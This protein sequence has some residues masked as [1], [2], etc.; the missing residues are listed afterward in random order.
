MFAFRFKFGAA[1]LIT[2]TAFAITVLMLAFASGT[3]S[4]AQTTST[5]ENITLDRVSFVASQ[6]W[7]L[8]RGRAAL[9]QDILI[10]RKY[11]FP[12]IDENQYT[13]LSDVKNIISFGCQR[14]NRHLDYISFHIPPWIQL[15]GIDRGN[16]ISQLD[17]RIL[18]DGFSFTPVAE[19][20]N[21]TLFV[22]LNDVFKDQLLRLIV[23]DKI[24]VEFGPKN[25]RI[26]VYQMYRTPSGGNVVGFI[27][28]VVP[29]IS[30]VLQGGKVESLEA[31]AILRK[32][33]DY[34]KTGRY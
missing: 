18:G 13:K 17:L 22:D 9:E 24:F 25:E 19:Y 5:S 15:N 30:S 16:W 6:K 20:R 32:C 2:E 11:A 26:V 21:G 8:L 12:V 31:E 23:S 1:T 28:D 33:S 29:Q 4:L 10:F 34:K 3:P 14:T 7:Y 27:D